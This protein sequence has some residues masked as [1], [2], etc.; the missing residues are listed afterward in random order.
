MALKVMKV[1]SSCG[2]IWGCQSIACTDKYTVL[3]GG[4]CHRHRNHWCIVGKSEIG[5]RDA[6]VIV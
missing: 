1:K 5:A 2:A 3:G 6:C 4:G